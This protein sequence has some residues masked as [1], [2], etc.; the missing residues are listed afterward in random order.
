M[1]STRITLLCAALVMSGRAIPVS[2]QA[3]QLDSGVKVRMLL[4]GREEHRYEGRLVALT[5]DSVIV[6]LSGERSI[7][8]PRASVA[9]L[10]LGTRP[11]RTRNTWVGIGIGLVV[12]AAVGAEVGPS[13]P[14]APESDP[15]FGE[16]FER[17]VGAVLF[18]AVGATAGGI[19]GYNVGGTHW[20]E[21][22]LIVAR[23]R[24]ELGV[25][26]AF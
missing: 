13:L 2:A 19:I 22:P 25:S 11:R 16:E 9:R 20:Q 12:G 5:T 8:V 15:V 21:V 4:T 10:D 23:G 26:F 7:R 6:G 3:I 14:G 17:T 24:P 18:G 1:R